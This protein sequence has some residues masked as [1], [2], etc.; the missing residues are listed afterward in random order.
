MH[1][2]GISLELYGKGLPLAPEAGIGTSYFQPDYAEYYSKFPAH[3]TVVVD[4]ISAYPEMRSNHG[5]KLN[6]CYPASGVKTNIFPYISFADLY[7]LEPE[8]NA[9]QQRMMSIIRTSDTTGYYV[10]VFRSA[11]KEGGDIVSDNND[12]PL[13]LQPVDKLAFANGDLFAY[14][15]LYDEKSIQTNNDI[16]ATFRLKMSGRDSIFMNM[17]MKGAPNR[18]IFTMKSPKSTSIDRG[19]VPKEISELPLPTIVARQYGEA[20]TKP[21]VAVFEPSSVSQPASVKSI[22]SF[23]PAKAPADFAGIIVESKNGSKETIFSTSS[24]SATVTYNDQS[25]RG[26][27]AVVSEYSHEIQYLFLGNGRLLSKGG[28]TL[29]TSADSASAVLCKQNNAWFIGGSHAFTLT[30]P[31]VLLG[32]TSLKLTTGNKAIT[33]VGKK[34]IVNGKNVLSYDLPA[35][36]YSKIE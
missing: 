19:I 31:Q 15:Y 7:F 36:P 4:G 24:G 21:F 12:K 33:I 1:A 20:F 11:K 13:N 26:T 10:D 32:K 9:G 35:M 18:E 2:N 16:K 22:T 34:K 5:F 3:N 17:W 30:I 8:T 28:I 27:Y 29:S 25:F 14:D 23:T 6:S